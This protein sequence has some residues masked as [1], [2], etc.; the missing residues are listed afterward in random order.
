[1]FGILIKKLFINYSIENA[2]KATS[3]YAFDKD[4]LL[5]FHHQLMQEFLNKN[6]KIRSLEEIEYH[7]Y[8]NENKP[9]F[10]RKIR[11]YFW[12]YYGIF[13]I[14]MFIS[15]IVVFILTKDHLLTS[16]IAICALFFVY[17]W[18]TE[19]QI[20]RKYE[21]D[22]GEAK[23]WVNNRSICILIKYIIIAYCYYFI[24]KLTD[25]YWVPVLIIG[26]IIITLNL[27]IKIG[28]SK[29]YWRNIAIFDI[30]NFYEN[31]GIKQKL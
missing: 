24:I 28:L 15:S 29:H 9:I 19:K 12:V 8:G 25:S 11:Y 22:I 30:R 5:K 14:L 16:A 6:K 2:L 26:I 17:Y 27:L 21:H 7:I 18:V 31:L 13:G 4:G 20:H 1:M 10:V 3:I 23:L